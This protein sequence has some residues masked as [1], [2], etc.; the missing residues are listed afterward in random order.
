VRC[1]ADRA[2]YE[3]LFDGVGAV[4]DEGTRGVEPGDLPAL[5][6]AFEENQRLLTALGVSAPE[7]ETLAATARRAGAIGAKLT[8]GGAGG[9][10]IALALDPERVAAALA[11][12][13]ASTMIARLGRMT[14]EAA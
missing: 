6:G 12:G 4:V 10:V 8:G 3:R 11:A 2:G 14:E 9:A 5:G 1:T 13:G 7:V